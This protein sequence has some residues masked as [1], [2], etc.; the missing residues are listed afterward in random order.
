[1]KTSWHT[2]ALRGVLGNWVFYPS[3]MSAE[4]IADYV[5]KSKDIREAKALDDYLQRDLKPRVEKIVAY[6]KGRD[7]RFFNAILLGVFDAAPNWAEFDLGKV[8][9]KLGL[10]DVSVAKA[11]MG[12]LTFSGLEKIFA[13]DGQHRV[14]GIR[15][16]KKAFGDRLST[17]QYPV[18]FLAHLDTV[19]G[20]VR[21]RRLFCDINKNAVPVSKGDRVI[22]D[23]DDASAIVT[24]RLFADYPHFKKGKE[25]AVTE[26]IEQVSKDGKEHFTSLLT[27]FTVCRKLKKLFRRP[28][29]TAENSPEN[30]AAFQKIVGAFFDFAIE[31]ERSL[32]RYFVEATTTPAKERKGNRNLVFRPIGLELLAQLYVQFFNANKLA[33]LVWAL[34]NLKWEN[35]G[36]VFDGTIW[37]NEKIQT[38]GKKLAVNY[39]LYLLKE[40]P[41]SKHKQLRDELRQ[42]RNEPAYELPPQRELP[43]AVLAAGKNKMPA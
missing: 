35:P 16:G 12:L 2:P 8:A 11:S 3:L 43:A 40:L 5:M 14:E 27:V 24:R 38:K 29:G 23:E 39:V 19:E 26:K 42:Y 22:I 33:V 17:D 28:K 10:G 7:S 31:H 21:T 32:H 13:I 20:K 15:T 9:D 30:V 25:V 37:R 36:G 34:T 18:I 41:S 6:L 1:M 4:Q